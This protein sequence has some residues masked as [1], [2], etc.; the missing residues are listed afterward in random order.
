MGFVPKSSD[1]VRAQGVWSGHSYRGSGPLLLAWNAR[2]LLQHHVLRQ[3]SCL[4][5]DLVCL[6]T[7]LWSQSHQIKGSDLPLGW[8]ILIN[9]EC[10]RFWFTVQLLYLSGPIWKPAGTS[11]EALF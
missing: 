8:T 11:P 7:H 4:D 5:A 1:A 9:Q 2:L 3:R 6:E 10:I